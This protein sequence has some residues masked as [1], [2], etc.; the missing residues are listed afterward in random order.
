[1]VLRQDVFVA[2]TLP[3]PSCAVSLT[4][5]WRRTGVLLEPGEGRRPTL[6]WPPQI[7]IEVSPAMW[8]R[9]CAPTRIALRPVT[10][11]NFSSKGSPVPSSGG[12]HSSS[13][14]ASRPRRS[15]M[16]WAFTSHP[17]RRTR[18]DRVGHRQLASL[19]RMMTCRPGRD[20]G[21]LLTL[22][23]SWLVHWSALDDSSTASARFR[24]WRATLSR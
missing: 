20:C 11:P 21:Q 15:S 17:G 5:R 9:S 19:V 18:P 23:H 6:A 14:G 10:P 16:S 3:V 24:P 13:D 12:L 4:R 2:W 8:R 1:M 7:P 22:P